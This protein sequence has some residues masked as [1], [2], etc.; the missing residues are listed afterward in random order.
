MAILAGTPSFL[1]H[2]L[3]FHIYN[4]TLLHIPKLQA[5]AE[6]MYDQ[7]LQGTNFRYKYN[8]QYE[9]NL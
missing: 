2:V 1:L 3:R 9:I 8:I 6:S 5:R 4:K 7:W